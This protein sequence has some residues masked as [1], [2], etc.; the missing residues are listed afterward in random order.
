M[1]NGKEGRLLRRNN[2]KD[3][4]MKINILLCDDD[5]DFL[6]RI[7]DTVAGQSVPP[8]AS[9]CITKSSNPAEITDRQ[10]SQ[11]HIMFLDIDMDERSG[12]DIARRVRELHLDA[13]RN[14]SSMLFTGKGAKR[15]IKSSNQF[16]MVH[17][18]CSAFPCE[19]FAYFLF[20]KLL[21]ARPNINSAAMCLCYIYY[22]NADSSV[23]FN[24]LDGTKRQLP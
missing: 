17:H 16:Q 24:Q 19:C 5:K 21:S 14:N 23:T 3:A 4:N 6:Q 18:S 9:I 22:R 15:E 20:R 10:L 1:L 2:D 12:M 11:Y 8:G 13:Q 7:S